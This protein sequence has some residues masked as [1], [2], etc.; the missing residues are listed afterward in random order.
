MVRRVVCR[1]CAQSF[2]APAVEEVEVLDP[3]PEPVAPTPSRRRLPSMPKLSAPSRPKLPTLSRPNLPTLPSAPPLPEWLHDPRSRVWRLASIPVAVIA[4]IAGLMVLQGGSEDSNTPFADT[5]APAVTDDAGP[6]RDGA[7]G[8]AS[9][10]G[11]ASFLKESSF[12]LALPAGWERTDPSGG[13]TFA[14]AA[15]S[16][17]ADATLWVEQDEKLSFQE[18]EARSLDTLEALAGSARVVER[19][20]A[21]TPDATV[22]RLAADSPAGAP[23]YEVTLRASGPYRYYLATTVQPDAPSEAIEGAELIHGSFVPA[24]GGK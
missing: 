19:V 11:G 24:G 6:T 7:G 10:R 9:R 23:A 15:E 3:E 2:E 21:P 5:A 16:G 13:A 12:S 1:G 8:R 4:V 22:V 18:F 17:D 14:A 20:A